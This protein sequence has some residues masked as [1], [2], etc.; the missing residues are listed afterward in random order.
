VGSDEGDWCGGFGI[1]FLVRGLVIDMAD[2]VMSDNK[3]RRCRCKVDEK[4]HPD[5]LC[6]HCREL[7]EIEENG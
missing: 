3:Q 5:H 1:E 7:A 2:C 6:D 4:E